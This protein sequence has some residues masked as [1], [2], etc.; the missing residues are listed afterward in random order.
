MRP[1]A[2]FL[3]RDGTLIKWVHYLSDPEQV[4]LVDGIGGALR[5]AKGLGCK[6]FIHSNQSGVG[7]G[8]FGMEAVNRVNQRMF[9]LLGVSEGFFDAMCFATDDPAEAGP[10][11]YR[12]PS[13]RF[14]DE[15]VSRFGLARSK[16]FMIGDSK[17][18]VD[19]GLRAGMHSVYVE[20]GQERA[21]DLPSGILRFASATDFVDHAFSDIAS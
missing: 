13:T 1:Q 17:C 15:M 3:D 16:C 6:L 2:L 11:S 19:T 10:G 7:R 20:S 12:K 18:D 21:L 14:Q 8:R 9:E 4:E 5:R